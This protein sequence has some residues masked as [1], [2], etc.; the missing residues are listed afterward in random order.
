MLTQVDTLDPA[1]T[2]RDGG[3]RRPARARLGRRR[4]ASATSSTGLLGGIDAPAVG[5]LDAVVGPLS[6][7]ERRRLPLARLL[8]GRPR[9]AA[10]R[11]ADQP[12]RRRG[13]RLAGRPPVDPPP[14]PGRALVAVTHDRWF[15]DAVATPTWEVADGAVHSYEGGYAAYVLAR[16]SATG[17]RPSTEERRANLLR[18]ELAWLRRGP[19]ARTSKPRVPHRR[20]QRAHRG[21]AAAA[22]RRRRWSGSPRRGWARTSSTSSTRRCSW[23]TATHPRRRHLAARARVTGS[24][25]SA[26]TAPASRRCCA[27]STGDVA[28]DA[29]PAQGRQDRRASPILTQEVRELEQYADVA[30]HRGGRGRPRSTT[31]SATRRSAPASSRSGSASPAAGSRRASVTCP[32]AS[33]G[34]C[35]CCGC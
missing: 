9:P 13:R 35:S 15:L 32:A 27:R 6:G 1:A 17:S 5:G 4:R 28:A 19:P 31:R 22:R 14:A 18:K 16:P 8:V 3:A 34:G 29:R 33:G 20:G 11:R 10:A 25:S 12:P 7:G 23:A 21:R 24:A 30:G 26:S 2:V